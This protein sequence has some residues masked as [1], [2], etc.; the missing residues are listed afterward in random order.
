MFA[1]SGGTD[2]I[3]IDIAENNMRAGVNQFAQL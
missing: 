1:F 2:S 3:V